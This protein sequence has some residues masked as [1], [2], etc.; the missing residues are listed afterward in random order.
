MALSN[1]N[2]HKRN[3]PKVTHWTS[4]QTTK[5]LKLCKT[6][7]NT[8][9]HHSNLR[10]D[11]YCEICK[12]NSNTEVQ[13]DYKYGLYACTNTQLII[14]HL[15]NTFFQTTP[16][17]Q[18]NICDILVTKD[19]KISKDFACQGGREFVNFIWDL[20][21]ILVNVDHTA[22]KTPNKNLI[23]N[24]IKESTKEILKTF[25]KSSLTNFVQSIPTLDRLLQ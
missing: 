13:E 9:L 2:S 11:P 7:F 16:N 17:L 22:G 4:S 8:Q 10:D 6:Q 19:T 3:L 23:L 24:S 25:P 14:K 21:Q 1:S 20:Y 18:F 12:S 5:S 15:T